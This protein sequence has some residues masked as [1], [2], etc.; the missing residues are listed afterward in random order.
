M[1]ALGAPLS[2]CAAGAGAATRL[3]PARP[4][5][6][7]LALHAVHAPHRRCAAGPARRTLAVTASAAAWPA[8]AKL[9]GVCSAL[10]APL[11]AALHFSAAPTPPALVLCTPRSIAERRVG[12]ARGAISALFAGFESATRLALPRARADAASLPCAPS[13]PGVG[14]AVPKMVL[15]NADLS[16]L[17]ETNDEWI[18]ARTGPRPCQHSLPV[19]KREC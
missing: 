3:T 19:P 1:A 2:C 10:D 9:A 18:A 5:S 12:A 7:A 16:K 13:T 4:V 8:G 14:S 6:G 11:S 15:T 17:V